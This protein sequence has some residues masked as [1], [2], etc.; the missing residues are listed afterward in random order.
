MSPELERLDA[1]DE[2]KVQL[3]WVAEVQ[4]GRASVSDASAALGVEEDEFRRLLSQTID[5]MLRVLAEDRDE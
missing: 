4:A 1:S 5:S 3:A 2:V